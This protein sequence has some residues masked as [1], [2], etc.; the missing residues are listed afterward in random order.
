ML[1]KNDW[2]VDDDGVVISS[3][4]IAVGA[5]VSAVLFRL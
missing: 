1:V 5:V 4:L 3:G 2:N